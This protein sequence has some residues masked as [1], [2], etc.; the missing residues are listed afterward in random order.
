MKR[1]AA[2]ILA[3]AFLCPALAVEPAADQS[4][5]AYDG[6]FALRLAVENT[7]TVRVGDLVTITVTVR[8]TD[9][10]EPYLLFGL[11]DEIEYDTAALT[12]L[13]E[14]TLLYQD[15][16]KGQ[17]RGEG[18]KARALVSFADASGYGAL[19]EP[20]FIAARLI[21]R[22]EAEGS[23]SL[24]QKDARMSNWDLTLRALDAPACTVTV[25]PA[26]QPSGGGGS[27]GTG[28]APK[29]EAQEGP[30]EEAPP[31]SVRFR[32][33]PAG[34][35]YEDAVYQVCGRGLFRGTGEN[36]FSPQAAMTRA[37]FVAVLHRLSGEPAAG[38]GAR[39]FPDV[40]ANAWYADAV[41][42]AS[43]LGVVQ[44]TEA[45]FLLD[46][47]ITREQLCAMMVRYA[48]KRGIRLP[49]RQARITFADH[50]HISVWALSAVEEAQQAGLVYGRSGNRFAPR[51]SSTR[52]E[53]AMILSRL[54]PLIQEDGD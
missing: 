20:E 7:G 45:G 31:E 44:G 5:I 24:T 6:R 15:F 13:E 11:Q 53:V 21:F 28:T 27:Y 36:T 48:E 37:M 50:A 10:E 52:A 12:Y 14:R 23:F 29:H 51:E 32:D 16:Q 40:A 41:A 38:G 49:A 43:E 1:I 18:G 46:A 9:R 4:I 17:R 42:W 47:P 22:A 39:S 26:Q 54:L 30:E 35:W 19:R 2:A 34:A 3:L 8:R 25:G 33:V